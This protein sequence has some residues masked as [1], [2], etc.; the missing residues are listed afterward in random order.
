MKKFNKMLS[1]VLSLVLCVSMVAPALAATYDI[2]KG[3]VTI[4]SQE[5][6]VYVKHGENEAKKDETPIVITGSSNTNTITVG[7]GV[8]TDITL[9][10]VNIGGDNNITVPSS[11]L[12]IGEGSD[13]TVKLE[14]KNVLNGYGSKS[15]IELNNSSVTIVGDGK[16]GNASLEAYSEGDKG[17]AIGGG[18]GSITIE[19]S[20]VSATGAANGAGIGG[21][22]GD[23]ELDITIT[24]SKVTAVGG[25]GT[26]AGIGGGAGKLKG[27]I[28]IE[29][30]DIRVQ[31]GGGTGAGI[32]SGIGDSGMDG[33][34]T[35]KNSTANEW[36][37]DSIGGY[38][39]IGGNS[40]DIL[41]EGCGDLRVSGNVN[42]I[43]GN[44]GDIAITGSTVKATSNETAIGGNGY[45]NPQSITI[46]GGN[47]TAVSVGG[48]NPA[49]GAGG[50][51][52]GMTGSIVIANGAKVTAIS[53]GP[54]SAVGRRED[55][56]K[57]DIKIS[58]DS[59]V[60]ALNNGSE[61][62]ITKN[63][64]EGYVLNG[65]FNADYFASSV[66]GGSS[67]FYLV[68]ENGNEI[69]FDVSFD[70]QAY[71]SFGISLPEGKYC[72]K[73]ADGN[74]VGYGEDGRIV[75]YTVGEDN[76]LVTDT[77]LQAVTNT[78][79][80]EFAGEN[81][82]EDVK[83]LLTEG[84][85]DKTTFDPVRV[86]GGQWNF[87]NWALTQGEIDENGKLQDIVYTGTWEFVADPPVIA[88]PAD[89]VEIDD[90]DVPL[91]GLFTRA[92][93]IGYLWEQSGSPEWELSDFED[94][95]EDHQWAVAIGWAQDMGIAVAD[96]DGNF[97]PDDLVLR[98]VE[99]LEID[100]EG[101]LQEFL[102]RYAV[103][104]G[105][106]LEP[107]ELFIE[108]DGAWDDIIM[109]EEAQVIFDNFFAR[110]ELA[111]IQVA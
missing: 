69:E 18:S 85:N 92:D 9:D 72:I 80:Y 23:V 55:L 90:V 12:S 107:G 106:K 19:K 38:F 96:E 82:P 47:V 59:T 65:Q 44:K 40:G 73:D 110:L 37:N 98:S 97:R 8:K 1:V 52:D 36:D 34:I 60:L 109:G 78:V 68:D 81:L 54:F 100:P 33:K 50:Y 83:A 3:N 6:G 39:G 104:A 67:V 25:A 11:A 43:G 63:S 48:Q 91:A 51:G 35:I 24:G 62:A 42:G 64:G 20:V 56:M 53:K 14:G 16:D 49:I 22:D 2:G 61:P 79:K 29:D 102:N 94:V 4:T 86:A 76:K 95:P 111:L 7:E 75:I 71:N 26:G 88:N 105:I 28:T 70:G 57:G 93:A 15:A 5:D 46:S 10:N 89:E 32:G 45:G 58:A 101:E 77:N 13:V 87:Q 30:S 31:A 84:V 21:G 99:D 41:I 74:Y 108:L 27:D 103:Y 66:Q 17:T